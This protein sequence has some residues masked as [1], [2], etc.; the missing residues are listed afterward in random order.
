MHRTVAVKV[1]ESSPV[2][3]TMGMSVDIS[4]SRELSINFLMK[5]CTCRDL[6]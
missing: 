5:P 6:M 4:L 1:S 2:D 3:L